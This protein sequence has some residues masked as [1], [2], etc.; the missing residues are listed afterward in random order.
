[1]SDAYQAP[2]ANLV[3]ES[4]PAEPLSYKDLWLSFEGRCLRSDYWLRYFLP[5]LG[6][7]VVAMI[8]DAILTGGLLT[9]VVA[10]GGIWPSFAVA[11]KRWHDR[12]KSGWW[13]LINL[14]PLI[15]GI[16]FLI[17]VGCLAGDEGSNDYGPAPVKS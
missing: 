1:M 4:G 16:W 15:G 5:Y 3:D 17:E 8:I 11:A 10:L 12:N 7:Y 14:V 13:P 2:E 9:V 6:I